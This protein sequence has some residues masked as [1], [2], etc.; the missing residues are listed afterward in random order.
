VFRSFLGEKN[1]RQKKSQPCECFYVSDPSKSG[2]YITFCWIRQYGNILFQLCHLY[3]L[4]KFRS[5]FVCVFLYICY[6]SND[7]QRHFHVYDIAEKKK[8]VLDYKNG[9]CC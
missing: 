7:I 6:L 3:S 2:K 9:T 5:V 1:K 8:L 4:V